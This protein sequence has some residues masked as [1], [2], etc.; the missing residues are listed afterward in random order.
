V[1]KEIEN[2][3]ELKSLENEFKKNFFTEMKDQENPVLEL[4]NAQD[5]NRVL[6]VFEMYSEN[7]EHFSGEFLRVALFYLS[8]FPARS[9]NFL[10]LNLLES[11]FGVVSRHIGVLLNNNEA[12]MQVVFSLF[13]FQQKANGVS[14]K[15]DPIKNFI[16]RDNM[17][18]HFALMTPS[19]LV[20]VSLYLSVLFRNSKQ[21]FL[22]FFEG[23]VLPHL[24]KCLSSLQ[25]SDISQLI[26]MFSNFEYKK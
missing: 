24:G 23:K 8:N 19:E 9:Y 1:R 16:L 12:F 11:F 5:P 20:N 22:G 3:P 10:D 13:T 2:E 14:L 26:I 25:T 17:N 18:V 6:K 15:M 21:D 7:N 4:L